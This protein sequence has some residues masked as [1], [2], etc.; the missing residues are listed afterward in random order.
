MAQN[1]LDSD[2]FGGSNGDALTTYNANWVLLD[3][4][5]VN[6]LEIRGT[7]GVGADSNFGGELRNGQTWTNDQW[8]ELKI[9]GTTVADLRF[10][11]LVR[12]TAGSSSYTGYA[13]GVHRDETGGTYEI[14]KVSNNTFT[15][16]QTSAVT[17][18]ANDVVNFEAVGTTLNLVV[19]SSLAATVTDA[20]YATG[21]PAMILGDNSTNRLAGTWKAG[22][23]G[24]SETITMD[25]WSPRMERVVRG[26]DP[27][28]ASGIIA[29]KN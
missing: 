23:V 13:G 16:L 6:P 29:V 19:N 10:L 21:S 1:L 27:R 25:K 28:I 5:S 4:A 26:P 3:S 24:S 11:V 22:S 15:Q 14:Y 8:A 17:Y 7:P 12:A 20:T 9:D 2:A 18:A